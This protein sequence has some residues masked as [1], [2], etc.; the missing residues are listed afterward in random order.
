VV[1]S[2]GS[3]NYKELDAIAKDLRVM[4]RCSPTDKYNLVKG[5]IHAGEVSHCVSEAVSE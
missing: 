4:A 1:N 5:L 3:L 2:D